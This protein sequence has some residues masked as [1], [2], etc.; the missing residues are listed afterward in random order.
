MEMFTLVD[1]GLWQP[2]IQGVE[3]SS[4]VDVGL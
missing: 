1:V 3:V 2:D 4:L